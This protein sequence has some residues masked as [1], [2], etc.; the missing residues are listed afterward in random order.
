MLHERPLTARDVC[1]PVGGMHARDQRIGH[2]TMG[3]K[4]HDRLTANTPA[5]INVRK[6]QVR[7]TGGYVRD[8]FPERKMSKNERRKQRRYGK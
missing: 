1:Q 2:W 8:A 3:L 6:A 7:P 5:H 4:R